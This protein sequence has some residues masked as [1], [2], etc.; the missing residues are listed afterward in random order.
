VRPFFNLDVNLVIFQIM[1]LHGEEMKKRQITVEEDL[2][3]SLPT[4]LGDSETLYRAFSN[5]VINSIQA[6]PNGGKLTTSSEHDYPSS[7]V[8]IT[9]KDTGIGMD[10]ETSKNLFNPFFTTK[11][12]GSGLGM[13]L[14]HKIV[15]DHLGTIEVMSEEGKGTT[16]VIR[17][18]VVK[19]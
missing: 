4:I 11:D 9:F 10:R 17:L 18:P 6:M 14:T 16:I 15:E 5:V 1:D 19:S 7:T 2:N 3:R 13:A 12:K 8:K